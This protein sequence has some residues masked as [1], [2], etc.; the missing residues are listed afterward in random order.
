M[1]KFYKL[2]FNSY[3]TKGKVIKHPSD[4]SWIIIYVIGGITPDEVKIVEDVVNKKG[5]HCPKIT[6]GGSRLLNPLDVVDKI[7]LTNINTL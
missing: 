1:I 7:L 5:T 3:L 4:N 6:L 2:L